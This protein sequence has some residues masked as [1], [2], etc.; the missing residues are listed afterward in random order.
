MVLGAPDRVTAVVDPAFT[1]VDGQ[2]SIILGYDSGA[3]AVLTCTTSA[4]SPTRAAVVGT[5]GRIEVDGDFYAPTSFTFVPREGEP[6]RFAEPHEGR[7]LRYEAD[8]VAR[9]LREGLLESPFMP[10]D[11][12]IEV[13]ETMDAVLAQAGRQAQHQAQHQ[14]GH[15]VEAPA[16]G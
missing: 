14:A 4:K 9:C 2:T 10:L 3:Q 13:M 12:T 11:E 6:V 16:R 7:G 5:E 15:R 1:G 8:E